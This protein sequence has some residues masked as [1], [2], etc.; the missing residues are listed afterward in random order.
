[1]QEPNRIQEKQDLENKEVNEWIHFGVR[2]AFSSALHPLDYSKT[3][4][5]L[6]YEPIPAKRGKSLLGKEVQILPNVFSYAGHIRNTDGFFGMYRGLTPKLAGTLIS[7]VFSE[8]IA[9][10]FGF[11]EYTPTD[12][13]NEEQLLTQFKENLKRDLVVE[14]S[15]VILAHPFHVISVRMMA[16]FI[17]KETFY[18]SFFGSVAEIYKDYGI[19]G[20]FSGMIPKLMFEVSC[21]VLSSSTVFLLNKYVIKDK[22]ARQYNSSITQFAYASILYPLQ[23]VSTCMTVTGSRLA[24]GNL[25]MMPNYNNWRECWNDLQIRDELKR[26][27][28]LFFRTAPIQS[29]QKISSKRFAVSKK[30]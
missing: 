16:Q 21:L 10:G 1:M 9:E 17:G 15:G 11:S 28:S 5:Q 18:N 23:V 24:A 26:G 8:K 30:H 7:M 22:M 6:G 29:I 2:L 4:I 20:F 25:P 3:L 12:D 19:F 27:S 13:L 14:V